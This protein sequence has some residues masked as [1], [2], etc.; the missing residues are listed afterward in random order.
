MQMNALSRAE[1]D[2]SESS[3]PTTRGVSIVNLRR[4]WTRIAEN[5]ASTYGT[6][7][8]RTT[9][10]LGSNDWANTGVIYS[11]SALATEFSVLAGASNLLCISSVQNNSITFAGAGT[12]ASGFVPDACAITMSVND[13]VGGVPWLIGATATVKQEPL[14]KGYERYAEQNWDGY[15]AEPISSATV[16]ATRSLLRI[17]PEIFGKPEI[18]PGSDGS[19]GLEWAFDDGP[20]R[21]LFIDVGPEAIWSGYWRR[22]SGENKTLQ[23]RPINAKTREE[24]SQLFEELSA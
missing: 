6:N 9:S 1:A 11:G 21:K 8:T 23:A 12:V 18:A 7:L 2:T 15:G 17:L 20:L 22:T 5:Y 13:C 19:I 4:D 10:G 16:G 3:R 14:L 24:L